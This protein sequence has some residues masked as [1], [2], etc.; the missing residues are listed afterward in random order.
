MENKSIRIFMHPYDVNGN[1]LKLKDYS[2][3]AG[4]ENC[5]SL[6]YG[7]FEDLIFG[8]DDCKINMYNSATQISMMNGKTYRVTKRVFQPCIPCMLEL[9]IQEIE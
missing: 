1:E 4:D 7:F 6:D 9:Y 8:E 5:T 2:Y 3:R